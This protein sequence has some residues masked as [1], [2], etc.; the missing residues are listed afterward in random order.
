M[1][2]L[3]DSSH[4]RPM[5]KKYLSLFQTENAPRKDVLERGV[6]LAL[7][8]SFPVLLLG[9][10]WIVALLSKWTWMLQVLDGVP[11]HDRIFV[12]FWM[13]WGLA[14]IVMEIMAMRNFAKTIRGLN[15]MSVAAALM[16]PVA[17]VFLYASASFAMISY[18]ALLHPGVN[19]LP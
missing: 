4:L 1:E 6:L 19:P 11:E 7:L 16:T 18:D 15:L 2:T 8:P 5:V 9:I 10:V 12:T 3:L 13:I 17:L 14:G